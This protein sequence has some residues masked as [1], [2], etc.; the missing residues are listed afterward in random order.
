LNT[1]LHANWGTDQIICKQKGPIVVNGYR[2]EFD[3]PDP[4]KFCNTVGAPTCLRNCMGR[5]NCV[6]GKC[7]CDSG[8][9]G[10]DCG[11]ANE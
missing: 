5:G 8:Y 7:V 4:V 3:C 6:D 1:I 9:T 2:G 10:V 11:F